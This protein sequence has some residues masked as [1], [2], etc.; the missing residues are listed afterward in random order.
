MR[1]GKKGTKE[2]TAHRM[3][4][5]N[6][7]LLGQ[8]KEAI[9]RGHT[10]TI[11]VKGYSMRPF[12]EHCRDKVRLAPASELRVGDAVL[13]EISKDVYVLHRVF[14][15]DGDC[16]TLMG[17]GNLKGT[18][19]CRKENVVGIVVSYVRNGK[20]LRADNPHL[21]RGVRIWRKLLP[22]R[23]YLLFIY[24]VNLKLSNILK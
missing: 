24:K 19:R 18:E 14:S 21:Q 3:E 5:P 12:L 10:A 20:T 13:A 8:V 6:A 9:R 22:V 11:N 7:I 15:I 2:K 1:G 23:R 16:V 4:I 17:D